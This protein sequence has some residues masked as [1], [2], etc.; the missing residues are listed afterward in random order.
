MWASFTPL[1]LTPSP[2]R[3]EGMWASFTPLSLT[4]SPAGRGDLYQPPMGPPT[5]PRGWVSNGS[6]GIR[7]RKSKSQP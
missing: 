1:S 7:R 3:G 2:L 5:N 6:P 4:L